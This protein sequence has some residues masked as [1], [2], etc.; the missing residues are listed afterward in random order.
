[1]VSVEAMVF[2]VKVF[3][4]SQKLTRAAVHVDSVAHHAFDECCIEAS[5]RFVCSTRSGAVESDK[6]PFSEIQASTEPA[7]AD[8]TLG[9]Y[10]PIQHR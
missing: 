3:K 6:Q 7:N 10:V 1:M 8:E 9:V 2:N 5:S 4:K